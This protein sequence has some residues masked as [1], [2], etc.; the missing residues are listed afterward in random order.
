MKR[1]QTVTDI[2]VVGMLPVGDNIDGTAQGI[3]TQPSRYHT[4]VN[5]NVV[6]Q[7]YGQIGQGHARTFRVERYTVDE[8]AH[9]I[10]RHTIDAKVEV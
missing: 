7:V 9:G 10:A 6:N 8:I 4:L 3:A 2:E 1:T 5:L